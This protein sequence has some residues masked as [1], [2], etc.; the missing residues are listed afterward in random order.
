MNICE[1]VKLVNNYVQHWKEVYISSFPS[2]QNMAFRALEVAAV[3]AMT[4]WLN[5]WICDMDERD[6]EDTFHNVSIDEFIDFF[7]KYDQTFIDVYNSW[8]SGID[9]SNEDILSLRSYGEQ[10][11]DILNNIRL[12]LDD[13]KRTENSQKE[14][15]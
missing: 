3:N 12:I 10:T 4:D 11:E 7:L 6:L 9:P 2:V 13:I 14:V 8:I 5:D 15:K 1:K